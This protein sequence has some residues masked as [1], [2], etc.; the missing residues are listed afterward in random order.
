MRG[1]RARRRDERSLSNIII[2]MATEKKNSGKKN[3]GMKAGLAAA[4]V[5]GIAAAVFLY[6]TPEGAKRRKQIRGWMLKAKGEV[7]ET[8]EK[9][10]DITEEQYMAAVD[11]VATKYRKMK[12]LQDQEVDAFASEMR[13]HWKRIKAGL[14]ENEP[15]AKK[16][17][18]G[19]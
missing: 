2:N 1:R 19:K 16:N 4:A 8:L 6:G 11:K 17:G 18:N 5:L 13:Q 3:T 14:K 12:H 9:A 15:R 7:L 10:K